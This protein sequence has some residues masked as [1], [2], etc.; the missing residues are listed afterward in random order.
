MKRIPHLILTLVLGSSN[1]SVT[2]LGN[3]EASAVSY[4]IG[5]SSFAP[6]NTDIF[7]ADGLGNEARPLV[8]GQGLEYNASFTPDGK[9]IIFTSDRSGS[10]DI[11]K[12]RIDG[13]GIERLVDDKAFDDQAAVS[14]DG[15]S[16][17]FVSSRSGQ[18]D[19]W[20]LDLKTRKSRNI[21]SHPA[22]D[23]RPSWSPDG[24]WLAFSS[25]RASKKPKGGGGFETALS[26]EIYV[27]RANG[28]ELKQVT[29]TGV[30]AGGPVW[31]SD[32]KS[33][34]F[35]TAEIKDLNA[36]MS[37]RRLRGTTQI[38]TVDVASGETLMVTSGPGEKV[39]PHIVG[40]TVGYSSG[41]PDGGVDLADGTKG[42]RGRFEVPAWSSDGTKMIFHRDIGTGWPPFQPAHSTDDSFKLFRMGIFASISP[43]TGRL[44]ANDQPAA[45]LRNGIVLLNADGSGSKALF[46][47]AERSALAPVW[48]P[49]GK[50]IAF[51]LGKFFQASGGA[52]IA[53]IAVID[54]SGSDLRIL[55]KGDANYGFPNWSPDGKQIVCRVA[56]D[57]KRGLYIIDV[58]TGAIRELTNHVRDN[59]PVWSPDG[60]SIAFTGFRDGD[61]ELYSIKPDGTALTRLTRLPGNDGHSSWS[62][63]GKW[64]AFA[65]S[66]QGFKDE[67]IYQLYNPQ[68]YG[69]I[70][71]MR[72]D[73]SDLRILTDNQFEDAT[74]SW[75]PLR[76]SLK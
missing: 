61:F 38:A 26:T 53:D 46:N 1:W 7:I 74:P 13:T 39:A 51:G 65:T 72:S 62:P 33:I 17:A 41:G 34:V 2:A 59:F 71:V 24:K 30:F 75:M 28:T 11:F 45:V 49:D 6:L 18:A 3:T 58:E 29:A 52:G 36:M 56:T 23:F 60:G 47:D 69:E 25:D 50:K 35:H 20:I 48:S 40:G 31:S 37:P 57:G 4:K 64:I 32:G 16:M 10:A 76:I 66:F 67:S 15:R 27:I 43:A 9:W 73:G 14:P 19:I 44:A 63:D 8:T 42:A 12:I 54:E 55:T 5:Y 22:G 21:T 70:A 68:P